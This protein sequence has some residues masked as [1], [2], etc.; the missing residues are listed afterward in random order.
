V[1]GA[2]AVRAVGAVGAAAVAVDL[3]LCLPHR[4]TPDM[5]AVITLQVRQ[6]ALTIKADV[7]D[8]ALVTAVTLAGKVNAAR[9]TV[10][11]FNGTSKV[12]NGNRNPV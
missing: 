3:P 8:T 6:E 7:V 1:A 2:A 9:G 10:R 12:K 5:V 11:C 4:T